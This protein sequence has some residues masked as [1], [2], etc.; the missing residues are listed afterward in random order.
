MGE[1]QNRG[2]A[3]AERRRRMSDSEVSSIF[4]DGFEADLR[5]DIYAIVSHSASKFRH[6]TMDRLWCQHF[7]EG[8]HSITVSRH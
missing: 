7:P 6:R 8:F 4:L 3:H 2:L 5:N 1:A